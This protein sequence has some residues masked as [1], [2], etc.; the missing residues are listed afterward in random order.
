MCA[1]ASQLNGWHAI[2]VSRILSTVITR[3]IF[4]VILP[5]GVI[6]QHSIVYRAIMRATLAADTRE[7][8]II[9]RKSAIAL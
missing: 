7:T 8:T 2:N 9:D 3:C 1:G 5:Y 4:F 6:M